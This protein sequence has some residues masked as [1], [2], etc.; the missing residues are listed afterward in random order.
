MV[1]NDC[2]IHPHR[3]IDVFAV[4]CVLT[5]CPHLSLCPT[6]DIL[7]AGVSNLSGRL[8]HSQSTSCHHAVHYTP[9]N[10]LLCIIYND[11]ALFFF[12]SIAPS[13]DCE[14]GLMSWQSL[15]VTFRGDSIS[16]DSARCF[17]S[18]SDHCLVLSLRIFHSSCALHSI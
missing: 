7:S 5:R 9:F 14:R 3:T 16:V 10:W 13:C 8:T 4:L 15:W 18:R 11:S 6:H 2:Y 12:L 1:P 17:R